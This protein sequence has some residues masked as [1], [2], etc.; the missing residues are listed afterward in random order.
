LKIST[1]LTN[2]TGEEPII[3][4]V[5]EGKLKGQVPLCDVEVTSGENEST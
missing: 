4:N 5:K 3:L 2:K 1:K